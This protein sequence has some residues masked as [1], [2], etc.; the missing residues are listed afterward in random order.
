MLDAGNCLVFGNGLNSDRHLIEQTVRQTVSAANNL[1]PIDNVLIRVNISLSRT[2]PEI[3]IGGYASSSHEIVI[4]INPY[5]P[6]VPAS[7]ETELALALAHELHHAKRRRSVGYGSTLLEAAVSEGLADHFSKEVTGEV[8][9]WSE[10]LIGDDLTKWTSRLVEAGAER[11]HN[12]GRWFFGTD[13]AIPR[14]TG[15]AVGFELVQ[16]YLSANPCQRASG[17]ADEPAE[18]FLPHSDK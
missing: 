2:I 15:Y 1:M 12:H 16:R 5:S 14:W 8:P 18:T 13:P 17:L 11:L 7:L 10:A 3:G 4:F 6:A 9:I